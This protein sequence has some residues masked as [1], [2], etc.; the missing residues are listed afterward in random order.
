MSDIKNAKNELLTTINYYNLKIIA[1]IITF[2]E[3]EPDNFKLKPLYTKQDYADFLKFMDREYNS[4]YGGQELFGIIYCEDGIWLN[5][6]DY[7]GAEWW[8]FNRYP[9]LRDNFSEIEVLR[10]ERYK[11]MKKIQ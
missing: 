4:G 6:E 10:Y 3:N 8:K 5:R 1:A 2:G 9:D 11:K 7:D